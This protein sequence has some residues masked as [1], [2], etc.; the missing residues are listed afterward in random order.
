MRSVT[1]ALIVVSVL[2]GGCTSSVQPEP[3]L[4][5]EIVRVGPGLW[6]GRTDGP[7]QI[8]VVFDPYDG[9]GA[10]II[11]TV[12]ERTAIVDSRPGQAIPA[13]REI[14]VVGAKVNVT[15]TL[16]NQS[17]PGQSYAIAVERLD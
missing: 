10:G 6:S 15:H 13:V 1:P 11:F 9:C 14:L 3:D 17:C 2:L 5:P 7:F 16:V 8:Q 4:R 12:D